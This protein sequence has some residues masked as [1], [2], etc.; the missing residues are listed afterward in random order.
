M[1]NYKK[2]NIFLGISSL[3]RNILDIFSTVYLYQKGYNFKTIMLFFCILYLFGIIVNIISL[4]IVKYINGKYILILS[5]ILFSFSFYYLN[6]MQTNLTNLIIFSLLLSLSSYM[7]HSMRHYYALKIIPDKDKSSKTFITLLI[8]YIALIISPYIGGFIT[9]KYGLYITMI[10][11]TIISILGII[12]IINIKFTKTKTKEN[13][14]KQ[15]L[16]TINKQK[17]SFFILEQF[18]VIFISLQPLYLYLYIK[19]DLKYI[20]IFN[21]ILGISSLIC[22]Y[23]FVKKIKLNHHFILLNTIFTIILIFKLNINNTTI[24]LILAFIEGILL[25]IYETVSLTNIYNKDKNNIASYLTI[26]ETIFCLTRGI[27][28]LISIFINDIRII[29]YIMILGIF[30]SSFPKLDYQ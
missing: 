18:K 11:S 6:N 1:N 14:L 5:S 30:I 25:K 10:I 19:D 7:Y 4:K 16:K 26:C 29:M 23:L 13:K 12:P 9:D 22:L 24:L 28:C 17:L 27:L 8:S 20:G 15:T 3:S 21:I 2:Y